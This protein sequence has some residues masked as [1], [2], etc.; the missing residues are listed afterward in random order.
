MQAVLGLFD[1]WTMTAETFI[2]PS[3][4]LGY[5]LGF[6]SLTAVEWEEYSEFFKQMRSRSESLHA[7]ADPDNLRLNV[8]LYS[9]KEATALHAN[10]AKYVVAKLPEPK[11]AKPDD[12]FVMHLTTPKAAMVK[13]RDGDEQ[14]RWVWSFNLYRK[15]KGY[16]ITA[17]DGQQ[18][19]V[20]G[21]TQVLGYGGTARFCGVLQVGAGR[22]RSR[23]AG[24]CQ[25]GPDQAYP[26][27]RTPGIP[28]GGQSI[29]HCAICMR[30]QVVRGERMVLHGYQRPGRGY[31]IGN[32]FG[33][34]YKPY[35][36]GADACVEY[37]P[38]L[39]AHKRHYQKLLAGLKGG[40]VNQFVQK[41]RN[42]RTGRDDDV[43]VNRGDPSFADMLTAEI[44]NTGDQIS[45]I[46]TDIAEMHKRVK[47]W[48][49]GTLRRVEGLPGV[50]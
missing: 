10:V 47:N 21:P 1:G 9:E 39:E 8:E 4:E 38:V 16:H 25:T 5:N 26:G 48:K 11:K 20:C 3:D 29:G 43:V 17:P 7:T 14:V 35:E 45:Y 49:P 27:L 2:K 24:Q 31:I 41:K 34:G 37:I 18:F 23:S 12:Y 19:D 15:C 13:D 32:C 28:V 42:Y 22:D 50:A 33:T 44:K 40:K 30:E 36:L 46:E 6:R